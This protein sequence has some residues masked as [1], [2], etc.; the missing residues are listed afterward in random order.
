M[1]SHNSRNEGNSNLT[2]LLSVVLC[3][4][5]TEKLKNSDGIQTKMNRTQSIRNV[6]FFL[7]DEWGFKERD[8]K[9]K[10]INKKII[11]YNN[12]L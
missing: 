10:K 7:P 5:N 6:F 9:S 11:Y 8:D 4:W 3:V 12:N 1:N 2:F